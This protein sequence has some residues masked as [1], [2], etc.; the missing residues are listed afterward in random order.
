[1]NPLVEDQLFYLV[2]FGQLPPVLDLPMYIDISRDALSND[3]LA[4]YKQFKEVYKLDVIQC[5]SGNSQEQQ[6]FREL[7]L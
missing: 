3:G 7:L 4:V 1:M 5:Q 2:I 6:D